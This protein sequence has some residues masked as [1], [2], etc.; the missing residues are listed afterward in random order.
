MMAFGLNQ[1][2]K[3]SWKKVARAFLH[4]I[5]ACC[6]SDRNQSIRR[7][8]NVCRTK[9]RHVHENKN[10]TIFVTEQFIAKVTLVL[11]SKAFISSFFALFKFVCDFVRLFR[12]DW[13]AGNFN[14]CA[15][16]TR[17]TFH[18]YQIIQRSVWNFKAQRRIDAI[19]ILLQFHFW[20]GR[21]KSFGSDST[22]PASFECLLMF[23][24]PH[25]IEV[26]CN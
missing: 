21:K 26:N 24:T 1:I 22:E 12:F 9:L 2:T 14:A 5:M 8:K 17:S 3:Y 19:L 18:S 6:L 11:L 20:L 23:R 4:Y 10:I 15:M 7:K 13:Y 16:M 25:L